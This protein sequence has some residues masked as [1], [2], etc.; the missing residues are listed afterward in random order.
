MISIIVPVYNA[1][2]YIRE[3]IECVKAQT[4]PDWE[5]I[6]VDDQSKDGSVRL[7]E[8][9][10]GA[11][12]DKIRLIKQPENGGAANARNTGKGNA[13]YGR[14]RRS[15]CLHVLSFRR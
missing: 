15:F 14:K 8:E 3:T 7:I 12:P 5:L 9:E 11:L 13:L 6:L 1:E 2:K 4:F 10:A